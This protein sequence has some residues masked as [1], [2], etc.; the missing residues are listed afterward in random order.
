MRALHDRRSDCRPAIEA[1]PQTDQS[2]T[3]SNGP[4]AATDCT[5]DAPGAQTQQASSPWMTVPA[6]KIPIAQKSSWGRRTPN[7]EDLL[8]RTA[9]T[10]VGGCLRPHHPAVRL[11]R[12]RLGSAHDRRRV[13]SPAGRAIVAREFMPLRPRHPET[14]RPEGGRGL[15]RPG[16]GACFSGQRQRKA[17]DASLIQPDPDSPCSPAPPCRSSFLFGTQVSTGLTPPE[18]ARPGQQGAL[19]NS[20]TTA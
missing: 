9:L 2:C 3:N 13:P 5:P 7:H 18:S 16:G 20:R 1:A 12:R 10:I 11:Q 19:D 17:S 4:A 15:M 8:F 6:Q 14:A